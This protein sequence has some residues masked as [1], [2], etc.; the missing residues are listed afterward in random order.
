MDEEIVDE[1]VGGDSG[2]LIPLLAND[3]GGFASR[4]ADDETGFGGD[5]DTFELDVT[6]EDLK[7]EG[8]PFEIFRRGGV[9]TVQAII[10]RGGN[11]AVDAGPCVLNCAIAVFAVK[12]LVLASAV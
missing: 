3:E 9:A 2:F 1:F 12:D 11:L 5:E 7:L 6:A 10:S 4:L 8:H